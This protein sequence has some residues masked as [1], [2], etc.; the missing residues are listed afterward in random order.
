MPD[1]GV[2]SVVTRNV[3]IGAADRAS[4]PEPLRVGDYAVLEI[5]D[6]GSGMP[7]EVLKRV[8]EPFFTTKDV[9]KGSGLGLSMVY[10]FLKQSEGHVSIASTP[11]GGTTVCLYFPRTQSAIDRY[12]SND[13]EV[14]ALQGGGE[15][16]LVV[17]DNEEVRTTAVEVL[18]SLGYRPIEAANGQQALQQ[19]TQHPDIA[20]VFSD[21]MLPGG[22]LGANLATKLRERR[23]GLKVLL[24]TGYTE[25]AIMQRGMLDGSL[26]VL[27]K[28]Y[29][30]EDLARRIRAILDEREENRRVPA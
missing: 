7:P 21:V 2:I 13:S 12:S 1:G 30:V 8:F 16:I 5:S 27:S 3:S 4:D 29:K 15:T 18:I 17:E 19:F 14:S 9:G 20:L 25:S 11:G 28:P 10:G 26:E 22:L 23:P 6:T 24:T